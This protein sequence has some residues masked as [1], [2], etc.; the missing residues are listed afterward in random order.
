M[1]IFQFEC[2]SP[3]LGMQYATQWFGYFHPDQNIKYRITLLTKWRNIS[4]PDENLFSAPNG[5]LQ[6]HTKSS[7]VLQSF[8]Y[9]PEVAGTLPNHLANLNYAI[10]IRMES[11]FCGIRYSQIDTF[12]FTLTG[13]GAPITEKTVFAVSDVMYG[14]SLCKTDYLLIAG[15]SETGTTTD[16]FYAKDRYC[17]LVLGYC[18]STANVG[19]CTPTIGAVTTFTKPFVVGVVTD[20]NEEANSSGNR[21][22]NLN[23]NQQPC[24]TAG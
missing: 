1:R 17:G 22:F 9:K 20:N 12:S 10:C 8:N 2:T 14:D 13:A 18:K 21:G 23:Y 11:G 15:G 19:T 3:V 6:Y 4:V 16:M 5:C 24:L 7:G